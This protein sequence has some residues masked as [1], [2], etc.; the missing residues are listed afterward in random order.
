MLLTCGSPIV[1]DFV[2]MVVFRDELFAGLLLYSV[3]VITGIVVIIVAAD[4][5]GGGRTG[6]TSQNQ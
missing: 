3:V 4:G 2:D 6:V 1:D 5:C